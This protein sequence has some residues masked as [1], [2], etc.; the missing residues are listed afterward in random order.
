MTLDIM[1]LL[2]EKTEVKHDRDEMT[3]AANTGE[4]VLPQ[5]A[6]ISDLAAAT[7]RIRSVL[8]ALHESEDRQ[9]PILPYS[10]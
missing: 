3:R 7:N 6:V 10:V 1:N 9:T 2:S 5:G 8:P 4:E